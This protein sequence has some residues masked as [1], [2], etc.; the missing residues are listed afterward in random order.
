MTEEQSKY[1]TDALEMFGKGYN[2]DE[3]PHKEFTS[4]LS[5]FTPAPDVLIQKFGHVTALVWGRVWRFC[6]MADG[7]CRAKLEN[8]ASSLGMS[9]RTLIRHL[10]N[11][12]SHGYLTDL[13]PD[14]RNKPH[15]YADTGKIKI[16]V[17][18]EA[19]VTL[20]HST[21]TE[22]HREGDR[23]SVEESIKKV[24]KKL[25][26]VDFE[27]SKLPLMSVRKAINEC[28]RLN[29]NWET[30]QAKQFIEWANQENVTPDQIQKAADVWWSDKT[31][32]WQAPTLKGIFEKWQM[33]MDATKVNALPMQERGK[34]FYV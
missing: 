1:Q 3:I 29:V 22:S 16:K 12:C 21:V 28:F 31:F 27:L 10:D 34:E 5:G 2:Q 24:N 11:L 26:T 33:L 7:V 23:E 4:T 15:I 14:I 30:K 19:G 25:D 8:M 32:N 13:T 6:Q 18:V 17:S 20:S 9:E